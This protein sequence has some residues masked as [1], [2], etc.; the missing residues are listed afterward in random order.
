MRTLGGDWTKPTG[1]SCPA[2][3]HDSGRRRAKVAQR[4]GKPRS[5]TPPLASSSQPDANAVV[6]RATFQAIV[7]RCLAAPKTDISSFRLR[8]AHTRSNHPRTM[9]RTA[10]AIVWLLFPTVVF[11]VVGRLQALDSGR[12][13]VMQEKH[14]AMSETLNLRWHYTMSDAE[15]F[16]RRLGPDGQVAERRF[17]EEDL[18]F[19][20]FYGGALVLSLLSMLSL[21]GRPWKRWLLVLPVAIGVAGDWIENLTQLNQLHVFMAGGSLDPDAIAKSSVATDAKLA[22]IILA[23]LLLIAL[24]WIALRKPAPANSPSALSQLGHRR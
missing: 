6:V 22:G 2:V 7:E 3:K 11:V 17:L 16:W 20:T 18:T 10:R 14:I 19:P 9:A 5:H 23:T 1:R 8:D 13:K 15:M 24:S 12:A 21:T 4:K